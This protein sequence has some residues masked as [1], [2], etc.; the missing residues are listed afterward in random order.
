[1]ITYVIDKYCHPIL[2]ETALSVAKSNN[3]K[4][5]IK[6]AW[7]EQTKCSQSSVDLI[8]SSKASHDEGSGDQVGSPD[9][10]HSGSLDAS[11]D[12]IT[13][14]PA[15]KSCFITQVGEVTLKS[16]DIT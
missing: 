10:L 7:M 14:S 13:P 8:T 3:L 12:L 15:N 11:H 5:I 9:S 16:R 4:R 2:G 1:M 6:E